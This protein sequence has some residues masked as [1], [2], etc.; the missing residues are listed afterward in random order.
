MHQKFT[1]FR[2]DFF[3]KRLSKDAFYGIIMMYCCALFSCGKGDPQ[4]ERISKE[5]NA[6]SVSAK[7]KTDDSALALSIK[8]ASG[9]KNKNLVRSRCS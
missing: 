3:E 4:W 2:K 9:M 1:N 5:K 8:P 7:G 6:A